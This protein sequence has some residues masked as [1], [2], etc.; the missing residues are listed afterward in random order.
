MHTDSWLAGWSRSATSKLPLLPISQSV[1]A[2]GVA[3]PLSGS[4][5]WI[6][7]G[8]P[9]AGARRAPMDVNKEVADQGQREDAAAK[10]V[11]RSHP[12]S[13]W[14]LVLFVTPVAIVV[15]GMFWEAG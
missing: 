2:S 7:T 13:W 6:M 14:D 12:F 11:V 8:D 15:I 3:P 1:E 4:R 5:D 9:D 10:V